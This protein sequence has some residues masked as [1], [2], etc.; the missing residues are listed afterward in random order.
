MASLTFGL[1]DKSLDYDIEDLKKF[2]SDLNSL[3]KNY[4]EKNPA[5]FSTFKPVILSSSKDEI[6]FNENFFKNGE[7]DLPESDENY[8][9]G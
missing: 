9:D 7:I 2:E 1:G 4:K 3:Y 5:I 6:I 8:V